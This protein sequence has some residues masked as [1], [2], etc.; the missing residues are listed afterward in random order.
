MVEGA[1]VDFDTAL[2]I[3]SRY[4]AKLIVGPVREEHD[5]HV[6]L[7][8]ERDQV[9]GSRGRKDVPR[10]KPQKVGILGA[11]MMGAG[12]AYAQASRGIATVLK[13]VTLDKAEAG[14]GLQHQGHAA[15]RR[16]GPHEPA[17]PGSPARAHH[18]DRIG[19]DLQGCDLI[20]EA[21]FENRELKARVTQE[22]E[23][24]ARARRL[25]RQQ[26]LDPADHRPGQ[27]QRAARKNSSASTS[28]ARWTR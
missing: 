20:I 5:Q 22:A 19:E 23:P 16:Q 14:Q 4:L 8:H 9:A 18:A 1:Q 6:L 15:A 27:G 12:I 25:L 11:G 26:H 13:D 28:S 24:H 7:Q 3:E 2:R 10:Y 21:V 17:R